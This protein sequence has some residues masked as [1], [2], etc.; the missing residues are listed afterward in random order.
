MLDNVQARCRHLARRVRQLRDRLR[1][2]KWYPCYPIVLAACANLIVWAL[3]LAL[4]SGRS[5]P[6]SSV[7]A[8]D[9]S[10][11]SSSSSTGSGSG[12]DGLGTVAGVG[13]GRGKLLAGATLAYSYGL[14][15]ALDADHIT[16]IDNLTRALVARAAAA[17]RSAR[18]GA[19]SAACNAATAGGTA[20]SAAGGSSRRGESAE[21]EISAAAAVRLEKPVT[22]GLFFSLGHSTIVVVATAVVAGASSAP[23]DK[24]DSFR[25]GAG[26]YVGTTVSM[27][28]LLFIGAVNAYTLA[29]G[30]RRMRRLLRRRR[31]T[32]AHQRRMQGEIDV[33]KMPKQSA[34]VAVTSKHTDADADRDE[35][36]H[37]GGVIYRVCHKLFRLIDRPWSASPSPRFAHPGDM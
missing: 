18:A 33:E 10:S 2:S 15:H 6:A 37:N 11:G 35:D 5:S 19:D 27:V 9:S 4:L 12:D 8:G 29:R 31:D 14:R 22:V 3:T 24:F 28:F 26:G 7:H 21:S 20:R 1:G 16:A 32:I 30:A 13:D 36:P 34:T 23:G 25:D 17:Y